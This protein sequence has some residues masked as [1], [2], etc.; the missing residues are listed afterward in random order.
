MRLTRPLRGLMSAAS[1]MSEGPRVLFVHGL[2]SGVH[3][4][5]ARFLAERFEHSH[6]VAMPNSGTAKQSAKDYD[7][8]RK[9]QVDAIESFRPDVIV[10][11][12]FGGAICM[13]LIGRGHWKGPAVILCHAFQLVKPD[14]PVPKLL[15]GVPYCLVHGKRDAVVPPEH[16]RAVV[17]QAALRNADIEG[18]DRLVTL[19][20]PDDTHGLRTVCGLPAK[21]SKSEPLPPQFLLD[22]LVQGVWEQSRT[23]PLRTGEMAGEAAE[24]NK[25]EAAAIE[26]AREDGPSKSLS[27]SEF[28]HDHPFAAYVESG[29]DE[30]MD[31]IRWDYEQLHGKH[32]K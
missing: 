2:E 27:F 10:G 1:S 4:L 14:A 25:T 18:G 7:E 9:L 28:Y 3:G 13:D 29:L 32:K 30:F 22:C 11:S 16:S 21:D 23:L 17:E 12:S 15:P 8:C 19:I 6:I 5:K 31:D 24:K 20:E 26:A